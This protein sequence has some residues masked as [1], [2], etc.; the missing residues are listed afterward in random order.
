MEEHQLYQPNALCLLGLWIPN[1]QLVMLIQ[2][3]SKLVLHSKA[4]DQ[5]LMFPYM[6]LLVFFFNT[7]TN[8]IF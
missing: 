4:L 6:F 7:E 1:M 3:S 5:F 8:T 2:W